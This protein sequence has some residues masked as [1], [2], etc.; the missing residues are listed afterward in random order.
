MSDASLPR[1]PRLL[2]VALRTAA[3]VLF[4]LLCVAVLPSLTVIA[5][6]HAP[7]LLQ[8][9]AVLCSPAV[10]AITLAIGV[11]PAFVGAWIR[12]RSVVFSVFAGL[13]SWGYVVYFVYTRG[14]HD[15]SERDRRDRIVWRVG[16]SMAICAVAIGWYV[17]AWVTAARALNRGTILPKRE[18]LLRAAFSPLLEYSDSNWPGSV[19]LSNFYYV[20]NPI[21]KAGYALAPSYRGIRTLIPESPPV[22]PDRR[23]VPPATVSA[24]TQAE[25]AGT[26]D[27]DPRSA[28]TPPTPRNDAPRGDK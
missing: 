26:D 25:K 7:W 17:V 23:P 12:H 5:R 20:V 8:V 28:A 14:T 6:Q 15:Y 13:L 3:V 19:L 24:G 10:H 2:H 16:A 22:R 21:P 11:I 9:A 18:P 1:L 27:A 4:V